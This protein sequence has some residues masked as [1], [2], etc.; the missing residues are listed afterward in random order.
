MSEPDRPAGESSAPS[1]LIVPHC[2]ECGTSLQLLLS[3]MGYQAEVVRGGPADVQR[4]RALSSRATLIDLR[5]PDEDGLEVGRWLRQALGDEV[6][7][8]GLAPTGSGSEE[9]RAEAGPFD[10]RLRKPV[11]STELARLLP[12]VGPASHRARPG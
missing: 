1:V 9:A 3:L 8:V 5:L 12:A 11:D 7:L 10:R 4:A 6:L 2:H